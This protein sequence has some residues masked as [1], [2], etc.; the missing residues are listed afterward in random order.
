MNYHHCRHC[1][2]GVYR[3]TGDFDCQ[4]ESRARPFLGTVD[5]T[6][7]LARY[8]AGEPVGSWASLAPDD[9]MTALRPFEARERRA[10]P[11]SELSILDRL[12]EAA[13]VQ[14]QPSTEELATIWQHCPW[15]PRYPC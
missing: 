15:R 9:A 11:G 3:S 2:R 14:S 8:F 6:G 12:A 1:G 7:D 13:V 10:R 5:H 4:R